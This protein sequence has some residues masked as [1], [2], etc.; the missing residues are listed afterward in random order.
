MRAVIQRVS[1]A[2]VTVGGVPVGACGPGLLVLLGVA[3]GDGPDEADALAR[4]VSRLRVFENA[5][6]KFDRSIVDAGGEALV[7]SQFTLISDTT[8]GN[9]PS[10][11]GA[12]TPSSPARPTIASAR[13]SRSRECPSRRGC[14]ARG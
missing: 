12:P 13:L 7:V 14:S 10:F 1:R 8:K 11:S 4:K 2:E 3:S 6:G 5:D 9:R